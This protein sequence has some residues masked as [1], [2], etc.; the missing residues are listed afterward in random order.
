[1]TG[2]AGFIA[3]HITRGLVE[4]GYAVRAFDDLSGGMQWSR[5][6]DLKDRGV[7]YLQGSILD[8]V[9]LADAVKGVDVIFHLAA[10]ISVAESVHWPMKYNTV[11]STGTLMVLE[12]ARHARVKRLVY[13]STSAI[14]GDDPEQPKR[15]SMLAAPG[16]AYAIGKF[17][18]ECFVSSYAKL[19]GMQTVSL[20]YFNVFGP[21]QNPKSQYGAAIPNIVSRMLKGQK[22]T[23]YGDGEQTRDFCHVANVVAA[24]LLAAESDKAAGQVL[25]VGCGQAISVN[26]I[27]KSVNAITGSNVEAEHT[28]PRPGEVRHSLADISAAKQVL[29]YE[30]KLMFEDGLR[31][32]IEWYRVHV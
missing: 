29:G 2:A 15:E 11:D 3:S 6:A 31:Q 24:N 30:P 7:S 21:G 14:Y 20:R 8:A 16:S 23:I 9:A 28:A 27:V 18:G 32:A 1:V 25:N 4:R 22:P 13:S 26:Q 5:I 10:L 19:H 17:G 12:A